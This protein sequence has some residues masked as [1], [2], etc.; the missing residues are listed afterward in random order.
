MA[1]ARITRAAPSARLDR[2]AERRRA[3]AVTRHV[4]EFEEL[5]IFRARAEHGLR[6]A[7][8]AVRVGCGRAMWA[9]V[10]Y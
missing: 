9:P 8:V 4:R 1:S 6:P 10:E 7:Y 3:A 2:V 5:S